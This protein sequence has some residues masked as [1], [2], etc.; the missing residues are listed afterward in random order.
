VTIVDDVQEQW[1]DLEARTYMKQ[2]MQ[3][4]G[5][6]SWTAVHYI[7]ENRDGLYRLE[8]PE[9]PQGAFRAPRSRLRSLFPMTAAV[10]R[11]TADPEAYEALLLAYPLKVGDSWTIRDTPE[12]GRWTATVEAREPVSTPAGEFSAFRLRIDHQ[13]GSPGDETVLWYA[14]EGLVK[15]FQRVATVI[16]PIEESWEL[17]EL[18]LI[19]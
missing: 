5:P 3:S 1:V 18:A 19:R 9:E 2:V 10:W 7:R 17:T 16:G 15:A 13:L 14:A 6:Y 8:L 12:L 11:I 4:R